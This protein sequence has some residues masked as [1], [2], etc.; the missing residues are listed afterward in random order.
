MRYAP[1]LGFV[2][3][4]S[5]I[6]CGGDDLVLPS[7]GE[8]AVVSVVAGDKQSGRVGELLADPV[9]IEVKDVSGRPV[10]GATVEVELD[11]AM[12][13]VSTGGDGRASA[14]LALGSSVGA[15]TGHVLVVAPEGPQPVQ[16]TFTATALSAS[17]NGLTLVSGDAQTG[18]AG[19][20][21]AEPLVVSVTD[22]FGNPVAGATVAWAVVGGGSV[23][24]SETTTDASGS[25]SVIRTLGPT[26]GPQSTTATSAGLAGSPVTFTHT[27]TSGSASGVQLLSGDGQTGAPGTTL[28]AP[29]VVAVSD[30]DGNPVSGAA[31]TWVVT[32][33]GGSVDPTTSTTDAAGHASTTWT[34]GSSVE[35]NTV[36]AVVSGVG[37]ATFT[38]HA[39]AG[40]PAHIRIISG[41]NQSGQVG[42]Q[43]GADLV[44]SVEDAD[45]NAVAGATVTWQVTEGGGRVAPATSTTSAS[46]QAST[47]WTLGPATGGQKVQAS[48]GAAG[49]VDFQA[50]ATAGAPSTLAIATQP[51]AT[52]TVGVPLATQPVIQL[53]DAT[54]NDVQRS[55]VSVTVAIATG[56]GHLTGTT[57]RTTDANGQ[58]AFT[59]LAITDG[60]G[61]HTLIFAAPGFTSVVSSSIT[62]TPP[63]NQ[64]PT[65]SA[66]QYEVASGTA[67]T[68]SAPGVLGNDNDPDGG[69]LTASA[70]D[71]PGNGTLILSSDGAFTY[72]PNAGFSGQDTFTYAA[73]DGTD[74]SP[75]ATV[76]IT[77]DPPVVGVNQPPS[78][79]PGGDQR[80]RSNA[81]PQTVAAWASDI[82][83][84]P[85]S[86]A[87]QVVTFIVKVDH[88]NER[89][90]TIAP[91]VS[92]SG[93]LT[94]TPAKRGK[95]KAKVAAHDDGGTANGGHDTSPE[96]TIAFNFE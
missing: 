94:Y 25:T 65:A 37:S 79:L 76:T 70:V 40:A 27:A 78:F 12:D 38:A 8:P 64:P 3:A 50:T 31:V 14:A 82:S 42:I 11:G 52:A 28:P 4:A 81:G 59:D 22:A 30:A 96:Y 88:K 86:E 49:H 1:L 93:T 89:Y 33:G 72:T 68:V 92:P 53:R 13:T 32:S 36:Q 66:D 91:T 47:E 73:G 39:V 71:Q 90:F 5:L 63:P 87:A 35:T 7:D 6:S 51:S 24:E 55:G 83:P 23:S 61:G 10:A 84:G 69:T 15:V 74:T 9:V 45:G 67:L 44:V 41:S 48:A 26:A 77:V 34:L 85:P 2:A 18:V 46:G 75:P 43:L 56:P 62:V 29:I 54:G 21:L 95:A 16:A 20:A 58:A 60:T 80:V 19:T 57:S 17:A